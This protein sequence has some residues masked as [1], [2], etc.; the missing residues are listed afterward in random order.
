MQDPLPTLDRGAQCQGSNATWGNSLGRKPHNMV[1]VC[2]Q[3]LDGILQLPDGNGNLKLQLMLQFMTTFQVDVFVAA[4]LNTCWDLL[5]PDQWLP[6]RTK[7][8][9]ENLHWS[10]SHN[11]NDTHSSIYQHGG[12]GIVVTNALSHCALKPG[13]DLLGLGHW[14]WVLLHSQNSHNVWIVSMYCPCKADSALST[15]QQHLHTLGWLKHDTCPKQAILDNLAKE[16]TLWQEA[17]NTVII[18]ADFNDNI[19]S[20]NLQM[21]FPNLVY[22]MCVQLCMAPHSPQHTTKVHFPLMAFLLQLHS[23]QCAALATW[24]LVR[25]F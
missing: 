25:G 20:D 9:W 22:P 4:E 14:C 6:G 13:D 5:P 2:F 1:R 3:N 18:T 8:W 17:G 7:G 10:L 19:C 11:R 21:F 12:T 24:L 23:F 15:Y 16:I